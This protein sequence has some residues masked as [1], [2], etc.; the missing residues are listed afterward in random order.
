MYKI[1]PINPNPNSLIYNAFE[2]VYYRDAFKIDLIDKQY[3]DI[4]K[5]AKSYF[6]SQPFYLRGLSFNCFSKKNIQND[7]NKSNFQ[8][9]TSIGSW[10]IYD[11]DTNEIV[12]GESMGFMD[13][14]FS[15]NLNR[16]TNTIEVSTVVQI[17]SFM[18]RYYFALVKLLHRKF[19][20]M[21]LKNIR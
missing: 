18:G 16:K 20:L 11:R 4:K 15:M 5:F 6:L 14:R 21:S 7:I 10:K 2:D 9:A 19:V 17:N 8:I 12:F 13:Y 3:S 1:T